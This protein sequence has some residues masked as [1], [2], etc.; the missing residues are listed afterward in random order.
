M[1]I[2]FLAALLGLLMVVSTVWQSS[3]CRSSSSQTNTAVSNSN[4]S[5]NSNHMSEPQSSP[6]QNS[7]AEGT[8][9]GPHIALEVTADGATVDYDC[10]HGR[11]T[12]KVVLNS[13]GKFEAKGV[14]IREGPG[15]TRAGPEKEEPAIYS[16]KSDGK[17]I[18]LT[19]KLANTDETVGIF[20]LTH[21]MSGRVRKC[22]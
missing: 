9:G 4:K 20:T 21:G 13:E 1:S 12:E 19:V 3:S 8:W 14:Y 16:G 2:R 17:T 5:Q 15:P 11:I 18:E 7:L 6:K 22:K 10:A